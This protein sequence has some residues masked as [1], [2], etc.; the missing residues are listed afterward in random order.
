MPR[1]GGRQKFTRHGRRFHW[2][3]EMG[4][5]FSFSV[6]R[7]F[8]V[9]QQRHNRKVDSTADGT[10]GVCWCSKTPLP[11]GDVYIWTNLSSRRWCRTWTARVKE[12]EN[13]P[14]ISVLLALRPP[15]QLLIVVQALRK[16]DA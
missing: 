10:P 15:A 7:A 5:V 14:P 2:V 11:G 13:T 3:T 4:G 8:H 6:A 12:N 16:S 9:L 1:A